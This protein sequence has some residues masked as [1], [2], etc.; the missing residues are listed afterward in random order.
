MELKR[1]TCDKASQETKEP[2]VQ[3]GPVPLSATR[4]CSTQ[5]KGEDMCNTALGGKDATNPKYV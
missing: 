3:S 4:G 1:D 5:P 2:L